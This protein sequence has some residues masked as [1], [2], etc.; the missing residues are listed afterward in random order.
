MPLICEKYKFIL[1]FF[2][3]YNIVYNANHIDII[4]VSVVMCSVMLVR[5]INALSPWKVL[6]LINQFGFA[7]CVTKMWTVGIIFL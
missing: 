7:I 3:A 5:R 1:I 2:L 6:N 4:A